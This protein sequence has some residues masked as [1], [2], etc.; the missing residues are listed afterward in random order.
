MPVSEE[1]RAAEREIDDC[2]S[3]LP[4]WEVQRDLVLSALLTAYSQRLERGFATAQ[5]ELESLRASLKDWQTSSTLAR[6]VSIRLGDVR[7]GCR[8]VGR[9]R[10]CGWHL[11]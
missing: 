5:R 10:E 1:V 3:R 8:Q 4:I 11:R 2:I 9:C 6:M 7:R